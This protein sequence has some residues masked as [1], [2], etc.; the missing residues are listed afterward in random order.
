[1]QED[2]HEDNEEDI[3]GQI[4]VC[5]NSHISLN[6]IEDITKHT[7]MRVRGAHMKKNL[8]VLID[9]CFTYNFIDQRLANMLCCKF[10]PAGTTKVS[11]ADGKNIV[12]CGKTNNFTWK[13]QGH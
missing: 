1:M 7:T 6:A 2:P 4:E 11:V 13:F 9:S 12:V 5:D 8:Y 3:S 10:E